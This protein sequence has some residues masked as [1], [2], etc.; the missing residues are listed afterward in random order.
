M[1]F[2]IPYM[3]LF[4][5]AWTRLLTFPV[6][7]PDPKMKAMFLLRG[8]SSDHHVQ[9]RNQ[10]VVTC[11]PIQMK[12]RFP[13]AKWV[14]P[15]DDLRV[16]LWPIDGSYLLRPRSPRNRLPKRNMG[17]WSAQIVATEPIERITWKPTWSPNTNVP[18]MTRFI[19]PCCTRVG[20]D[21][22]DAVNSSPRFQSTGKSARIIWLW[23]MKAR[24]G[25]PKG[26]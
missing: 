12:K 7:R 14:F 20:P 6:P 19:R 8:C 15:F 10:D 25:D 2:E 26:K 11:R 3:S 23:Q 17:F 22:Q 21:V 1:G 4:Y 16:H 13:W 9:P 24:L 5:L 18:Q